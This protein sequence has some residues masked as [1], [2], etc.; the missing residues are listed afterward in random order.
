MNPYGY[1]YG[2]FT[3]NVDDDELIIMIMMM[4]DDDGNDIEIPS[5]AIFLCTE[6]DGNEDVPYYHTYHNARTHTKRSD[7]IDAEM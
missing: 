4:L 2:H 7:N 6:I 1:T 5:S 3:V